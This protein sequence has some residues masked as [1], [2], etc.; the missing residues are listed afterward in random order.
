MEEIHHFTYDS[1]SKE[2]VFILKGKSKHIWRQV[3]FLEKQR[4][5]FITLHCEEIMAMAYEIDVRRYLKVLYVSSSQISQNSRSK[6]YE[7]ITVDNKGSFGRV[8]KYGAWF[9]INH[10]KLL[11]S[12]IVDF[13][14]N[15]VFLRRETNFSTIFSYSGSVGNCPSKTFSPIDLWKDPDGKFLVIDSYDNT[16]HMLD[17][18]GK[19]L[20]IIMSR[21]DGLCTLSCIAMDTSTWLCL[22]QTDGM[23]HFL[24]HHNIKRAIRVMRMS[25]Q[26]NVN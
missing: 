6:T 21:E 25:K 26:T 15:S 17:T 2:I 12:S 7:L 10:I 20:S 14:E 24:N 8:L 22:G 5:F 11:S 16:V 18:N 9:D 13:R 1:K 4:V 19:F 23:T 3:T